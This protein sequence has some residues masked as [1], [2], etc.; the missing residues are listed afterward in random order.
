M[1]PTRFIARALLVAG[2]LLGPLVSAEERLVGKAA[3]ERH[4]ELRSEIARHDEL[5]FRKAAPEISDAEYDSLK[6]ELRTLE[7]EFPA[8]AAHGET[9][10]RL[11]DDRTGRFPTHPHREP[12]LGLEK[13]HTEAELRKFLLR[14]AKTAAAEALT[15]LVEPKFDGLAISVTYERG[16]LVRAVTRGNGTEGDVVTENLL[17]CTDLPRELRGATVPEFVE[18][19]G[20]VFMTQAEFERLNAARIAAGAEI[21]AHPRNLAVG[22]LKSLDP[23]E[24]ASRRLT[25]VFFGWGAWM[26]EAD[27]PR[28]Q[29]EFY[30][31]LAAWDLPT[32]AVHVAIGPETVWGLV[33]ALDR[34]RLDFPAPLDGAVVKV[35]DVAV[36][37]RLGESRTAPQWAVAHKFEPERVETRL[38]GITLQIG[39]T[40]AVTPVA[41]LEPVRLGGS[42][43]A[44][45]TLHNRR[46]IERRDY[47]IGDFVRVERAGEVIPQ[48]VGVNLARRPADSVPYAFPTGCP[49]CATALEAEGEAGLRCPL[50][51]CTAQVKRRLEYAVSS[52]ALNLRGFGPALVATLVDRGRIRDFDD[53][54]RLTPA[55]VPPRV[56]EQIERS[57][58]TELWRHIAALGLPEVG[59]ASARKLAT[60]LRGLDALAAADVTTLRAAGL[61]ESAAQQVAEEVR[62]PELQRLLQA[63]TEAGVRP[64]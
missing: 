47:R 7:T 33:R 24:R 55:E 40:G 59:G 21:Y 37:R 19:R 49:S 28:A 31:R 26:P 20:E 34:G 22:T 62:R 23:A 35:D 57:K 2:L 16:R 29:T 3:A 4:A 56:P 44:R 50:R 14:A 64:E 53:L 32:P 11:G 30:P 61:T 9:S 63:L 18:L 6:R 51:A 13:T 41:E 15:W 46:E 36:R 45:A 52:S 54:Y 43:I 5:Y 8:L 25:V 10:D 39:R 60:H 58:R 42:V 17:A 1:N 38:L 27:E 12:M 48:L